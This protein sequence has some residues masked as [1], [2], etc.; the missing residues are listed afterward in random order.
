MEERLWK[1]YKWEF[2]PE[3]ETCTCWWVANLE[4][5]DQTVDA[6][7]IC[8]SVACIRMELCTARLAT[9]QKLRQ[10]W[11]KRLENN[12]LAVDRIQANRDIWLRAGGCDPEVLNTPTEIHLE[13]VAR[14]VNTLNAMLEKYG[15]RGGLDSFVE[16]IQNAV[17]MLKVVSWE[18]IRNDRFSLTTKPIYDELVRITQQIISSWGGDYQRRQTRMKAPLAQDAEGKAEAEKQV[19]NIEQMWRRKD[20][21]GLVWTLAHVFFLLSDT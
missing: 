17:Q 12:S 3:N 19:P 21:Y 5:E 15:P 18:A 9:S 8:R 10:E 7:L 14:T 16:E 13:A 6:K 11:D 4:S 2:P 1:R 20:K